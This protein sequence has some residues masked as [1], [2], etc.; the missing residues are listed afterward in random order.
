MVSASHARTL[1]LVYI[2]VFA[3]LIAGCSWLSIPSAVPFTMQTFAVFLALFLLGGKNGTLAVV[4]YLLLGAVGA[5]VF[6]N[7]QGGLGALFG[8]TGGYLLGFLVTALLYWALEEKIC[9][10]HVAAALG[11]MVVGLALCYAFGTLWFVTVYSSSTG[12][13]GIGTALGWCVVPYIVPDLCKLALALALA[14]RLKRHVK[15]SVA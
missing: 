4:V 5:P 1:Q 12:A 3:A 7:F 2:A 11:V 10:K 14:N 9:K 8:S 6:A 15:L 13:V